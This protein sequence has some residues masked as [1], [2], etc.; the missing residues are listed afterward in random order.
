MKVRPL[1]LRALARALGELMGSYR[2][3]FRGNGLEYEDSRRYV[4]GDDPRTILWRKSIPPDMYVKVSREERDLRVTLL[5]DVSGSMQG[6][7][8][9]M[10]KQVATLLTV[11]A[12]AAGDRI[13]LGTFAE[14]FVNYIPPRR[15]LRHAL[16]LLDSIEKLQPLHTTTNLAH[17]LE[18]FLRARP[19][20]SLLF[21]VSDGVYDAPYEKIFDK[22]AFHH[23]VVVINPLQG[24]WKAAFG[25][26]FVPIVDPETGVE[27]QLESR[28]LG[29]A[30]R[31]R[32]GVVDAFRK[33]VTRRLASY[34]EIKPDENP[35]VALTQ[36]FERRRRFNALR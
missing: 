13:A 22:V 20:R 4:A 5:L 34:V 18:G 29:Q 7:P 16:S 33:R 15:G 25:S 17:A 3:A 31:N 30:D 12:V 35:L 23:D 6:A 19:R 27:I 32:E 28:L 9:E 26:G 2:S 24:V 11:S 8:F 14:E 36:F 1:K 10:L 21:I